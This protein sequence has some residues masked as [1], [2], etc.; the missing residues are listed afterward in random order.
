MRRRGLWWKIPAAV[1]ALVLAAALAY[2]CYALAAYYRVEDWQELSVSGQGSGPAETGRDYTLLSYNIG[3]GAY[4]PDYSFFMDGGKYSRAL[5]E[6]AVTANVTG[7][8]ETAA[9][10]APDFVFLQEVDADATRSYHVDEQQLAAEVLGADRAWVSAQNYDSPYLFWPLTCPHGASRSGIMTFSGRTVTGSVRRSLPVETGLTR[11]L[12]LDRCYTVTRVPVAGGRELCLYNVHLSAYT[13]D[14]TIA[15]EQVELL[16]A[17]MAAEYAWNLWDGELNLIYS[18]IRSHMSE[19]EAE[20]LKREEVAWL[21]E[22]D[23]AAEQAYVQNDTPPKQSIQYITISAQKTRE[24]CYEL[25]EQY[26]DVLER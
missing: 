21:K 5:S 20:D 17:D 9:G 25:L 23:L 2:V 10:Q 18:H 7:A 12:D 4:S 8:L 13:S 22:R 15:T 11:Y 16:L 14:G 6:E 26:A 1:L 19:E 3:F 24:R